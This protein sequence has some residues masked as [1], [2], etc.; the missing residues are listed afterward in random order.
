MRPQPPG[1]RRNKIPHAVSAGELLR[2]AA[3]PRAAGGSQLES[4]RLDNRP[5]RQG[6]LPAASPALPPR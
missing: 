2:G 5:G 3:A 6:Q 4:Q 1:R